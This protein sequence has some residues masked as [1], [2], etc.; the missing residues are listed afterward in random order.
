M[1]YECELSERPAQAALTIR[2]RTAVQDLPQLIGK[3]YSAIIQHLTQLG[4]YPAGAPFA[5]YYNMDMQNL[6]IELGFPLAEP[7]PPGGD[8]MPVIYPAGDYASLLYVGP[9]D[10]CGPAYEELTHFIQE[11]GREPTG[12]A[13]E[14]YL[15]DPSEPPF[16]EPQTL[17]VFP[18][19]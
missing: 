14:Y 13:F 19:K 18:L 2:T 15:N 7:L 11:Q 9:Y 8:I 10:Q 12:V 4:Q 3:A 17:I 5:A 1:S 16:E 6:D